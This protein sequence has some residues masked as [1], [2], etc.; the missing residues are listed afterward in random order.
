MITHRLNSGK[1]S[2]RY[3]RCAIYY[4]SHLMRRST[5]VFA[6]RAPSEGARPRRGKTPDRQ[7]IYIL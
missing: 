5:R 6:S 3:N 1:N 4:R 7:D 2:Q